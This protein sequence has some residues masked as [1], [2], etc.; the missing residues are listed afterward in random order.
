[1]TKPTILLRTPTRKMTKMTLMTM[2]TLT[3]S[4]CQIKAR[5]TQIVQK[6]AE[7]LPFLTGNAE[8]PSRSGRPQ[9][10]NEWPAREE[11]QPSNFQPMA[12]MSDEPKT[13]MDLG[14]FFKNTN[15]MAILLLG[16]VIGVIVVSMRPI[17][18]QPK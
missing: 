15:P 4:S 1:M 12:M 7:N 11:Q 14:D 3:G 16:I 13:K 9:S 5:V 8:H 17:V 6:M 10:E 18:I 2:A